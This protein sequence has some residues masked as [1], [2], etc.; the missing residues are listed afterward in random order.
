MGSSTDSRDPSQKIQRPGDRPRRRKSLDAAVENH[1]AELG[2]L[3]ELM[4]A[5]AWSD[6]DKHAVEV[7]A[8]AEQLKEFVDAPTL[9]DHVSAR[10]ERFDPQRFDLAAAVAQLHCETQ[11]DKIGVLTLLARVTGA[12][13]VMH[14]GEVAFLDRVAVAMGLDPA[15]LSIDFT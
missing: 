13:R 2:A 12:D 3:A 8:I 7:V 10:M 11:G 14:P 5:A 15:A 9:P 4:L 1:V 6:G